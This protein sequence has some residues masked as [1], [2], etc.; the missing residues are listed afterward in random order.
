[1]IKYTLFKYTDHSDKSTGLGFVNLT[2]KAIDGKLGLTASFD[3]EVD[4][5]HFHRQDGLMK[6]S[7]S[8]DEILNFYKKN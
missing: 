7:G 2:Y 3:L 6:M 5:K 8:F 1:M 4:P